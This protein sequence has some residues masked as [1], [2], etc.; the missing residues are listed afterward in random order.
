MKKNKNIQFNIET[1]LE[2][3]KEVQMKKVINNLFVLLMK[4]LINLKIN[5]Q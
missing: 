5:K 2:H 1:I 4:M 3:Q